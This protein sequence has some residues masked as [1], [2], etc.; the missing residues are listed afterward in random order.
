M[1]LN[2]VFIYSKFVYSAF[3]RV[4][5]YIV[6]RDIVRLLI[7]IRGD[8]INVSLLTFTGL[9]LDRLFRAVKNTSFS[10]IVF[11]ITLLQD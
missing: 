3:I 11:L 4:H 9:R 2:S 7:S 1:K 5:Y 10:K 8:L 6:H